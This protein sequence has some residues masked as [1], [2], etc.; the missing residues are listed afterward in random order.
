MI[1]LPLEFEYLIKLHPKESLNLVVDNPRTDY[2]EV[3]VKKC[4]AG[5]AS[6]M[7]TNDAN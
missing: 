4:D 2:L 7:Y 6:I 3:N 1:Y 5:S